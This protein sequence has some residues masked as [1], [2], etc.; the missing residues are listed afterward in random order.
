M[1]TVSPVFDTPRL[2]LR[3]FELDDAEFVL[4]LLNEPSFIRYIGDK[5]VRNLDDARDYLQT[6]PMDSYQ[7]HGFGLFHVARRD[8]G[9]AV[10]MCGLLQREE[11]AEPDIGFAFLPQFWSQGY[12]TEAAS[13]TLDYGKEKLEMR[14]IVAITAPDN[15]SSIKLLQRIGFLF[16]E[17]IRLADDADEV[18]LFAI[19]CS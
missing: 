7:R 5:G 1:L 8:D 3:R 2:T 12:A 9:A 11:L 13:A 16:E 15:H 4:E 6:G 19:N 10:G 18:N 14:R 17:K